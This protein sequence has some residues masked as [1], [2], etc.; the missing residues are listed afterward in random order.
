[1]ADTDRTAR[2]E[3]LL[4]KI[5]TPAWREHEGGVAWPT[6]AGLDFARICVEHCY[7][8]A[9]AR[10]GVLDLKTRSLVTLTALAALGAGDELKLHVRGALSLGHTPD[11]VVE[12]FIHLVP[13]LG[14]PRMVAAMRCAGEVLRE[15]DSR[16]EPK[17]SEEQQMAPR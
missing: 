16:S 3:A 10:E 9:W 1:M 6:A 5:F 7:A 13:Y 8:D 2:A 4:D 15:Q 11:D 17:A 12:L 14:V